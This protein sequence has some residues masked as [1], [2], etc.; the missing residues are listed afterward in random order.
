[1]EECSSNAQ[2]DTPDGLS[3][4]VAAF[5]IHVEGVAQD[6]PIKTEHCMQGSVV[7]ETQT[8][9]VKVQMARDCIAELHGLHPSSRFYCQGWAGTAHGLGRDRVG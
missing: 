7:S 8:P 5:L 3:L 4:N 2:E 1:M 6:S 9:V